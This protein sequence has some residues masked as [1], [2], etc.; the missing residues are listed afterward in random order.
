MQYFD[1]VAEQVRLT[2]CIDAVSASYFQ[3]LKYD[4]Q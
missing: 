4:L 2:V 3:Q 1:Q